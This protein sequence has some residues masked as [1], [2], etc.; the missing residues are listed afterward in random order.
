M[1]VL[2]SIIARFQQRDR[3]DSQTLNNHTSFRLPVTSANC[4]IGT[5]KISNAGILLTFDDDENSPGYRLIE[6]AFR[7]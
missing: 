2:M 4:N 5:E 7:V 3:H 6:E 1:N